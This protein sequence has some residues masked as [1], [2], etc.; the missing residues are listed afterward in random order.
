M[1]EFFND[2][3]VAAL[4]LGSIYSLGAIGISM[5][6]AILRFAHFAHGDLLTLG[7]YMSLGLVQKG[8]IVFMPLPF[9]VGTLG[10][11]GEEALAPLRM[12]WHPALTI[13]VAMVFTALIA[14][15][16]DSLFYRPFRKSQAIIMVIASFGIAL[17][18]RSAFQLIWGIDDH[19]YWPIQPPLESLEPFSISAK[20]LYI[21]GAVIVLISATHYLLA[22]TR[23]GK[24]MR[25]MSDDPD[26]ARITGI[27][28]E[29]I[30]VWTWIVGAALGAAA[31]VLLGMDTRVRFDMG[32][33]LLLPMFAAAIL[34]GLGRPYGAIAGGMVIGGLEELSTIV[35]PGDYKSAVA[36]AVMVLVL[37]FRPQGIFKGRML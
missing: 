31:G 14:I 30:V 25:A 15:G 19:Y 13:P 27:P 21:G 10:L 11:A 37:I 22:Y 3:I 16:I 12:G 5:I 34:G 4:V 24:A 35:I 18:L 8:F 29:R 7:A 26:L 33:N 2:Y 6:Y 20:H 9:L 36:F 1:I 17:M 23:T 32:W 28:T